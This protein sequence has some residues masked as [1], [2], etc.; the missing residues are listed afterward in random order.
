MPRGPGAPFVLRESPS[1][2]RRS[3]TCR[4]FRARP[5]RSR[6]FS[7]N[8]NVVSEAM[9]A[10]VRGWRAGGVASTAKHFPGLGAARANTD[11]ARVTIA[12]SRAQLD[13]DGSPAVRGRDSRRRAA[14]HG[15]TCALSGPRSSSDRIAVPPDHRRPVARTARLPR[16]RRDGLDGGCG[17]RSPRA[18][19]PPSPSAPCVPAPT[20]SCSRAKAPTRL[21]TS[22]CCASRRA[23]RPSGR[24]YA[25]RRHVCSR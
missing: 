16:S 18:T 5:S 24:A 2:W 12:R 23:R 11:D 19:S 1:R 21:S 3:A 13:D 7:T 10:A 8:V 15:R 14:G 17:P 20:S 9:A 25:S 6:S 4:A 22:T